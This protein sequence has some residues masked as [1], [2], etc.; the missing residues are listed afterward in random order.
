MVTPQLSSVNKIKIKNK[1]FQP[2][3]FKPFPK[4]YSEQNS[5]GNQ[6][7]N[8]IIKKINIQIENFQ[9]KSTIISSNMIQ[10]LLNCLYSKVEIY[11]N[12]L[13]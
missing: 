6:E 1:K 13:A 11:C 9:E 5:Q 4:N 10:Y 2:N 3:N 8:P 12:S 7:H